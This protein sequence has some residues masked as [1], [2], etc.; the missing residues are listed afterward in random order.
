MASSV[1]KLSKPCG[2]EEATGLVESDQN[3][4]RKSAGSKCNSERRSRSRELTCFLNSSLISGTLLL[5]EVLETHFAVSPLAGDIVLW[6][7]DDEIG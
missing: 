5:E 3:E 6:G 1:K 4:H 7:V 2:E